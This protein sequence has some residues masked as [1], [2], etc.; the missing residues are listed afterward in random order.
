MESSMSVD[1]NMELAALRH[2]T[3]AELRAKYLV[4]YGEP[5]RTGN[6]DFLRKRIACR[7]QALAEGS[8][9]ERARQRAMELAK[10]ADIRTTMPRPRIA[11]G[12]GERHVMAAPQ[13]RDPRLPMPGA[14][15]TREYK[16]RAIQVTVLPSGFDYDGQVYRSLSAVAKAVTGSHWN[17]HLFF[18]L[19]TKANES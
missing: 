14:V 11:V 8:L 5:S 2:M 6:K 7:I 18:N 4:V 16:G 13:S 1:M 15:L 19:T 17:G 9:S 10:D 3:P 12:N